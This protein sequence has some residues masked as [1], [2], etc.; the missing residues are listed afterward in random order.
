VGP[1]AEL[2]TPEQVHEGAG[3]RQRGDRPDEG[4]PRRGSMVGA[5]A[6][7]RGT[8]RAVTTS[9]RTLS[10]PGRGIKGGGD[11]VLLV[12]KNVLP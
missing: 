10:E 2:P 12:Y 1:V 4:T 9:R 5:R 7:A 11:Q 8:P 3:Q 6:T